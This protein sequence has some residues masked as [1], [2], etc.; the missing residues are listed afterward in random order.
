MEKTVEWLT[1]DFEQEPPSQ[2]T[3]VM[4]GYASWKVTEEF[5]KLIGK[6]VIEYTEHENGK[7]LFPLFFRS[8]S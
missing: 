7:F 8:K 5:K 4:S 2:K 3:K 1:L 6:G